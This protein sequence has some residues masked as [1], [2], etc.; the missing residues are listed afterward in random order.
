MEWWNRVLVRPI[1]QRDPK[2]FARLQQLVGTFC[3]RRT[4]DEYVNGQPLVP[5]PTKT[6]HIIDLEL[7]PAERRI[8]DAIMLQGTS[9]ISPHYKFLS[10]YRVCSQEDIHVVP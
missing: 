10:P 6:A 2:G 4:K 3:L 8:Y 9:G 1:S 5:L 7:S